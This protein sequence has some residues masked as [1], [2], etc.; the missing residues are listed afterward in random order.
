MLTMITETRPGILGGPGDYMPPCSN[1]PNDPRTDD[2]SECVEVIAE[3]IEEERLL[4]ATWVLDA[5][6]DLTHEDYQLI[7]TAIADS[8]PHRAGELLRDSVARIIKLDAL[9]EARVRMD[10]LIREDEEDAARSVYLNV[11]TADADTADRIAACIRECAGISDEDLAIG[12]VPMRMHLWLVKSHVELLIAARAA[13]AIFTRQKWR[14]DSTDP[15]AVALR[16]LRRAIAGAEGR[17]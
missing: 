8:N 11:D 17:T 14:E 5:F 7:A 16:M 9:R 10:R 12:V 13:E 1:H 2:E 3:I 6:G 4:S 15:E